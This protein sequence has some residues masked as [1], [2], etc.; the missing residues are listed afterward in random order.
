M[1]RCRSGW[2][3]TASC[4]GSVSAGSGSCT[5]RSMRSAAEQRLR[6]T[7]V[8]LVRGVQAL[9]DAGLLH[10]DLKP[11]NVLVTPEGRVVVLDFG[12]VRRLPDKTRGRCAAGRP[13]ALRPVATAVGM[14]LA[15]DPH[16]KRGQ[17]GRVALAASH[18]GHC[19]HARHAGVR[20]RE[21]RCRPR[22]AGRGRGTRFAGRQRRGGSGGIDS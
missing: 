2:A 10:L 8:P 20:Q 7:L 17:H 22:V 13:A 19:Q 4:A 11:N 14:G 12:L 15:L 9:H 6:A 21:R 3:R 16:G 18:I 5:K 1:R